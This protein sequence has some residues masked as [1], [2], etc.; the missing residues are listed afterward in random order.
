[1]HT[2][3]ELCFP[4]CPEDNLTPSAA[5]PAQGVPLTLQDAR[6]GMCVG[7]E[8][9]IRQAWP[10]LLI[11]KE[12]LFSPFE[13]TRG[14]SRPTLHMNCSSPSLSHTLP[15]AVAGSHCICAAAGLNILMYKAKKNC[16]GRGSSAIYWGSPLITPRETELEKTHL[17]P[18]TYD[19][20]WVMSETDTGATASAGHRRS[21]CLPRAMLKAR[22]KQDES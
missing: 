8:G 2:F 14:F 17:Y 21:I 15:C 22:H 16:Q 12:M 19:P 1:M 18:L 4:L 13:V 3:P 6:T 20:K 7:T 9:P 11:R 5:Y 10:S